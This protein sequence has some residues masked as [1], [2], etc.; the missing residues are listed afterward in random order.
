MPLSSFDNWFSEIIVGALAST[1]TAIRAI[2]KYIK[3]KFDQKDE[4]ISELREKKQ[5]LREENKNLD[6]LIR[7]WD[8]F[9]EKGAGKNSVLVNV[10]EHI[11]ESKN[12]L[13]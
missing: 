11:V 8:F 12:L 2:V 9:E 7:I 6:Q 1:G 3:K 13:K 10:L 4:E 5:E